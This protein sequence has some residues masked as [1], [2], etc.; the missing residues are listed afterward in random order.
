VSCLKGKPCNKSVCQ[1][2]GRVGGQT[3][4]SSQTAQRLRSGS[5]TAPTYTGVCSRYFQA[6]HWAT[7]TMQEQVKRSDRDQRKVRQAGALLVS[8]APGHTQETEGLYDSSSGNEPVQQRHHGEASRGSACG[9]PGLTGGQALSEGAES[10]TGVE[11]SCK[12][13]LQV[14]TQRSHIG[15]ASGSVWKAKERATAPRRRTVCKYLQQGINT[16]WV[17]GEWMWLHAGRPGSWRVR[18]SQRIWGDSVPAM[19]PISEQPTAGLTY[20]GRHGYKIGWRI[21]RL[22]SHSSA[23]PGCGRRRGGVCQRSR[24]AARLRPPDV[25]RSP[26][27]SQPCAVLLRPA[28]Q[29]RI[30]PAAGAG[31]GAENLL[32]PPAR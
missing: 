10:E 18:A 5:L 19:S 16:S 11:T 28:L 31:A 24:A 22:G 9:C 14:R 6:A 15:R 3:K 4:R 13:G 20:P 2:V 25:S 12:D 23:G 17:P 32:A 30:S 27:L 26:R 21:C 8:H 29:R 1:R 7:R